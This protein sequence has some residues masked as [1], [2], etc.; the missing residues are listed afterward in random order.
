MI[1]VRLV[2]WAADPVFL[3]RKI[4]TFAATQ[5]ILTITHPAMIASTL[6]IA[7][8]WHELIRKTS[9]RV[10]TGLSNK[11][12]IP[13]VVIVSVLFILEIICGYVLCGAFTIP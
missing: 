11:M 6:L 8:Y 3:T 4:F 1:S 2:F 10:R 9:V 5:A 12:K 7:L 13:F